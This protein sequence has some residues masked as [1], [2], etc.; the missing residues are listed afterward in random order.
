MKWNGRLGVPYQ[1]SKNAIA[2]EIVSC[3][4]DGKRFVDVFAGGCAVTHAA[5]LSGKYESF[6][7]NDLHGFGVRLF[8]DA[9]AGKY[10]DAWRNWV[11]RE[12]FFE[13]KDTD[14]MVSLCWSFSNNGRDYLY[15]KDKEESKRAEHLRLGK[16]D[17]NEAA[18][19]MQ[20]CESHVRMRALERLHALEGVRAVE[21]IETSFASYA[22][23]EIREGDVVYCDPPY[24]DTQRYNTAPFDSAA[25]WKWCDEHPFP[26]FVSEYKAPDGFVPIWTKGKSVLMN[27]H[28]ADGK[29]SEYLFVQRRYADRFQTDFFLG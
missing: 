18:H 26:V 13:K 23:V 8:R 25:F 1:G 9:I 17:G 5:I 3:L 29:V 21:R 2:R 14:P 20:Q 16:G 10:M 22:D 15:A 6:L 11:S 12:E 24:A 4:P 28:G 27:Q 19:G 7:A